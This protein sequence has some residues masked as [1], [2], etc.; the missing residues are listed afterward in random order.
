MEDEDI[1]G[2][3][4]EETKKGGNKKGRWYQKWMQKAITNGNI[5]RLKGKTTING[6]T[7]RL[8]GKDNR[9][10]KYYQI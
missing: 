6:N 4:K 1:K 10:W 2:L 7:I 8:K 9:K 3:Q 5:I